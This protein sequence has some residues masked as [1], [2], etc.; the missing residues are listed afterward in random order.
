MKDAFQAKMHSS[1][2]ITSIKP[3]IAVS[4]NLAEMA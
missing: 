2:D 3:K 4:K 1:V